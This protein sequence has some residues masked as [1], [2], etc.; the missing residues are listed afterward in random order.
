MSIAERADSFRQE[1]LSFYQTD[2]AIRGLDPYQCRAHIDAVLNGLQ[3]P[4]AFNT[5]VEACQRTAT[6]YWDKLV[7]TSCETMADIVD[8]FRDHAGDLLW[9]INKNYIGVFDDHFFDN[10]AYT[11][12]IGPSGLLISD[13]IKAGFLILGEKVH[14]PDHSHAATE[15]YHSVS[16]SAVWSQGDRIKREH[17]AGTPVFHDEWETHAMWTSTPMLALWTWAGD[18]MGEVNPD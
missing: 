2:D 14:Y 12:I 4:L 9:Q 10:E 3:K 15:L 11:E 13:T 18:I 7:A 16:G 5:S 8:P 6:R 1:L 17:P